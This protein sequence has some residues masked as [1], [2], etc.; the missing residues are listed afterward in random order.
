MSQA[1][2]VIVIGAGHAGCEAA[3]AVARLGKR[4]AVVT[5]NLKHIGRLSCNPAIGGLAKGNLVREIDALGGIMARVADASCI[6]FRRLNTRKGLAVQASR[7]QVDMDAYPLEMQKVL[8]SFDLLSLV[9]AEVTGLRMTAGR[10]SGVVLG[11]GSYLYAPAVIVTAGTFLSGV[12][13]TGD[14]RTIG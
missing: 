4:V 6:Q 2:D 13:H 14:V 10:V 5:L 1:Y 3:A 7:A 12:L 9:E 11:D 8:A